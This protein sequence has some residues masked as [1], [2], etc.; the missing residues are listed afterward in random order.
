MRPAS[1]THAMQALTF[2]MRSDPPVQMI[3]TARNI[4]SI[5]IQYPNSM[6]DMARSFVS[7]CLRKH[8]GMCATNERWCPQM[9]L[10]PACLR[11]TPGHMH[12]R[13]VGWL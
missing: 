2:A 12:C 3:D 1:L 13:C 5:N 4:I 11:T 7:A 10:V 6:S 8:P 9:L